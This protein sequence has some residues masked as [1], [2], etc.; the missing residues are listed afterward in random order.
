MP[1]PSPVTANLSSPATPDRRSSAIESFLDFAPSESDS[2]AE[3]ETVAGVVVPPRRTSIDDIEVVTRSPV[4]AS[5]H[6]TRDDITV[7]PSRSATEAELVAPRRSQF[8]LDH[9]HP[10]ANEGES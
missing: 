5:Y 6:R 1:L 4:V 8:S 10:F 3:V 9:Q 2:D 7:M